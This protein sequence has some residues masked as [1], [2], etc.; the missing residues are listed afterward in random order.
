MEA[1]DGADAHTI[2]DVQLGSNFPGILREFFSHVSPPDSQCARPNFGVT[3]GESHREIGYAHAGG[4]SSSAVGECEIAV[5]VVTAS[6]DRADVDLI[7]VVFA[8]ILEIDAELERVD[9]PDPCNAIRCSVNGMRGMRGIGSARQA[10]ET[11][12]Q[13]DR[14]N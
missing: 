4:S 9:A 2:I 1:N 10:V 6:G 14:G 5:L 8:G 3:V 11:V 13:I 12:I 7:A